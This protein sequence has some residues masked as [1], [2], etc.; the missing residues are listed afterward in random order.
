MNQDIL[1]EQQ[2]FRV[3][4]LRGSMKKGIK[5]NEKKSV[6]KWLKKRL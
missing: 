1:E 5:R 4:N 3:N 6:E 2:D